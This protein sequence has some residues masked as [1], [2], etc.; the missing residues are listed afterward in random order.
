MRVVSEM[1]RL[2]M[3]LLPQDSEDKAAQHKA[4]G[5]NAVARARFQY[6]N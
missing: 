6:S 4:Q 2:K 1:E 5:K 3:P